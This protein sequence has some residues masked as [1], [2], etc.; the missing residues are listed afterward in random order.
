MPIKIITIVIDT[1]STMDNKVPFIKDI[2]SY[3][4]DIGYSKTGS[5]KITTF[6]KVYYVKAD[7]L[8]SMDLTRIGNH[9]VM[10]F[11][12][13][14]DSDK[15][16]SIFCKDIVDTLELRITQ[17]QKNIPLFKQHI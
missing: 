3:Y 11:D 10:L 5:I 7:K 17:L 16:L 13:D 9:I 6:H 14:F 8:N 2:T 15:V 1:F 12:T 4:K